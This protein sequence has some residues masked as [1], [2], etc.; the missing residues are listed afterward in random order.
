MTMIESIEQAVKLHDKYQYETK[1]DYELLPDKKTHYRINT[2]IFIP[3]SLDINLQTYTKAD[4]YR[5]VQNYIRLKTPVLILREFT[6]RSNSP[7][8]AIEKIISVE[9]WA[10]DPHYCDRLIA[11]FKFLTAMLKSSIREHFNLIEKRIEEATPDSNIN[12]LIQNLIEEFLAE[13]QKI[14][15]KYRSFFAVFNLPNVNTL[16]F[17][18]YKF[19]DESISLLLE[20]SAL[21][22]LQ[23]VEAYSRKSKRTDFKQKLSKFIEAEISHRRSHGYRSILKP[24]DQN[25][26]FV[27]RASTLKRY[28]A[29]V[30]F[31]SI[32]IQREGTGLEQLLYALAAGISMVFATVVAF[33][34]QLIYGNV[35]FPLF[36]ALVVG[37]MFKDRIK[38]LVRLYFSRYLQNILFDRRIII[39]TRDGRHKLGILKEKVSFVQEQDI[40]KKILRARNRDLFVELANN[41]QGEQ[42]IRYSKDITLYTDTFK[43]VFV[44]V[45][46]IT[47][48]N[49]IMRYDIRAY[50]NKM[51]EPVQERA[52][53]EEGTLKTAWCHKVYHLNFISKYTAVSSHREKTY[54][55]SRL[56]LNR[57]GIKRVEHVPVNP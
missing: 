14:I 48:V 42:I 29:S 47:G 25:E 35:T 46:E 18:A 41:G 49:D 16:V 34:F 56:V 52:Y 11:S 2:Y 4:F 31:L 38:E 37:Y 54:R 23:I 22:M 12:L 55:R 21:E 13:S 5:D 44:D 30:L 19:A 8:E 51:D 32:A 26:E 6:T 3:N 15:A 27:Y 40:P 39:R 36:V 7:L 53:F 20:E 28:A 33:Y 45:P 17:S 57:E 50:L 9:N 1:L 24:D 10:T 43:S